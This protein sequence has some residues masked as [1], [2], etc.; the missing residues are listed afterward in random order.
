MDRKPQDSFI[1]SAA[2][3]TL[4]ALFAMNLLNFIDRYILAA[5]LH[6]VQ[7]DLVPG[8]DA[9]ALGGLMAT[10]FFASYS[11][12]SP[13]VAYLEKRVKRTW[14]RRRCSCFSFSVADE[15]ASMFQAVIR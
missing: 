3:W 4:Q 2:F 15:E 12:F 7:D 1:G 9:D 11:I 13:I 14:L 8:T 10:I 5:V 6:R